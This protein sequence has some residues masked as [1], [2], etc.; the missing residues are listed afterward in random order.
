MADSVRTVLRAGII[1]LG[2]H[3][4][5]K[6]LNGNK[7]R[8]AIMQQLNQINRNGTPPSMPT[9]LSLMSGAEEESLRQELEQEI[10]QQANELLVRDLEQAG[11]QNGNM[12]LEDTAGM[13]GLNG[14]PNGSPNAIDFN[15]NANNG[16]VMNLNGNVAGLQSHHQKQEELARLQLGKHAESDFTLNEV[17]QMQGQNKGVVPS[18]NCPTNF[19]AAKFGSNSVT[20]FSRSIGIHGYGPGSAMYQKNTLGKYFDESVYHPQFDP[21]KNDIGSFFKF[22]QGLAPF[23][24]GNGRK[25]VQI[26]SKVYQVGPHGNKAGS[27]NSNCNNNG[28]KGVGFAAYDTTSPQYGAALV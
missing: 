26:D 10:D 2:L 28:V 4:L 15:V 12:M 6:S 13:N 24:S 19:D 22:N 27:A 20:P 25:P 9:D 16:N 1:I 21:A 8:Q 3:L 14:A 23:R 17:V 18:N 7:E 5:L 11:V